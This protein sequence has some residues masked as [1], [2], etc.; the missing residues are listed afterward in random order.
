MAR[1][2]ILWT[3]LIV[4]SIVLAIL[5]YVRKA[6]QCIHVRRDPQLHQHGLPPS[7]FERN[8]G[9]AIPLQQ[10]KH[11]FTRQEND[12]DVPAPRYEKHVHDKGIPENVKLEKRGKHHYVTN[13]KGLPPYRILQE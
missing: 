6:Y 1:Q 12:V 3:T 13:G 2:Q 10:L 8:W 9:D 5:Y 11:V 7:D 4:V